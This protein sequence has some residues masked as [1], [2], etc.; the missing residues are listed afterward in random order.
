MVAPALTLANLALVNVMVLVP[1]ALG[2]SDS[3]ICVVLSTLTTVVLGWMLVP[4]AV[5]PFKT[6][7]KFPVVGA[8]M[9]ITP[10]AM[11]TVLTTIGTTETAVLARVILHCACTK[12]KAQCVSTTLSLVPNTA[13]STSVGFA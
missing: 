4:V 6:W 8:V 7:M 12:S 13:A 2:A 10:L 1:V 11:P 5:A 9:V 3:V